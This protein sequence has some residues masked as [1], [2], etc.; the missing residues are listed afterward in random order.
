[1]SYKDNETNVGK[2][3]SD[4]EITDLKKELTDSISIS[5]I[6]LSHK[7][8]ER[9]IELQGLNLANKFLI[10]ELKDKEPSDKKIYGFTLDQIKEFVDFKEEQD[11]RRKEKQKKNREKK[12]KEKKE[13]QQE[14]INGFKSMSFSFE[15]DESF[16]NIQ[17]NEEQQLV[18]DKVTTTN[19]N[20]FL[21]GS[22]G[23]GK[24]YTLKKIIGHFK[25]ISKNVGITSTTGCSAILIG[26]RTLHS[27]LK[28]GISDKTPE[29]LVYNLKKHPE[30]I[31][32]L[33]NLEVLIIEEVSMLSD[34]LFTTI[35]KY[36][37]LIRKN[38]EPFGGIQLLLVGDFCQL[39]PI[40][41]NFCFV[42]EEWKRLNPNIMNLQS[43][44]RQ[45]GDIQF[46]KILEKARTE[47]ITDDDIS[48]LKECKK[49]D[50]IEY[51]CLCATNKEADKINNEELNKLK[52]QKHSIFKY[53][54]SMKKTDKLEL[55]QGCKVMVNWNVDI[56]AHIIN[57]TTGIVVSLDKEC[58]TIK[59]TNTNRFY[60]IKH[61]TIK[62][63]NT[64]LVLAII[65]PLQLAWAITIHKSQGATLDYLLTDLGLSIFAFGQAYVALSRVKTLKN[66]ALIDIRKDSFKTNPSVKEFY[67]I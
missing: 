61:M 19:E 57:G 11:L 23:T 45:D 8:S 44:V 33:A 9:A 27:Y 22:P 21:T 1:M 36:L 5:E 20:V 51:T 42:S 26:A 4:E 50:D 58:V 3:W 62:D 53:V 30:V 18:F 12:L 64:G 17:L 63:E 52:E 60:K 47:T 13:E 39:P 67:K 43:L 14:E 35:S 10:S 49:Q 7:R 48:I 59:I 6:A 2:K 32:K 55:C 41:D 40:N 15:K 46:Q 16:M 28:L 56:G 65:M 54:N 31:D 38:P 29:Q 24:S 37:S 34:K 25:Y 66:L